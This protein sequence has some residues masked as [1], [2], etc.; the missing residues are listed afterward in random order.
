MSEAGGAPTSELELRGV[1][2]SYGRQPV[3]TGVDLEVPAG[4]ITAVL[5]ASGSGKTTLLRVVAGFEKIES[6]MV[7]LGGVVV[8]DGRHAVPPER[9][10]IGYVPQDGALFPHLKVAANVGFGLGRR[11]DRRAVSQLLE[12][13]GLSGLERRYPYELSGGQ[14]QRVALAR[15]LAVEPA[16]VLLDEPFSALDAAM[17]ASVRRDVANILRERGATTVLVTHDQD[18]ALSMSDRVAI[19][20][21]G[22]IVADARPEVLY[23]TP[24]DADM[25]TFLGEANLLPGTVEGGGV[26][27]TGL[28][29]LVLQEGAVQADLG[30]QVTVLVRPEQIEARTRNAAPAGGGISGHVED[31]AYF[32]HDA[33]LRVTTARG[34]PLLVRITGP[35]APSPDADVLLTVRG[36][37]MAWKKQN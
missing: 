17:R 2:H 24:V 4:S 36:Q 8:D 21:G 5:G 34:D 31:R 20:R 28:G 37:V 15:A 19:L 13:V 18:E 30:S 9:R 3:L 10:R 11:A 33:V 6:G 22:R 12:L 29:R 14:Q 35:G 16:V 32:G 23:R 26:V 1:I 25:A 27:S 7:R